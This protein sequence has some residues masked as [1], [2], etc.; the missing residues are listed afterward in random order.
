MHTTSASFA[1][2][3]SREAHLGATQPAAL[4]RHTYDSQPFDSCVRTFDTAQRHGSSLHAPLREPADSHAAGGFTHPHSAPS[5]PRFTSPG[6]ARASRAP[7]SK[8]RVSASPIRVYKVGLR[9]AAF[10]RCYA[11][12]NRMTAAKIALVAA[13]VVA[14]AS[15]A[16]ALL[17]SYGVCQTGCNILVVSCYAGAGFTFGT[18]TAG[19][20]VPAAII[21]CNSALGSCMA[22]CAVALVMPTP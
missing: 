21:A 9:I 11:T 4:Q 18:I 13:L 5:T 7:G 14:A 2:L 8:S 16:D 20:G 3:M 15:H 10:D 6:R 17:A 19:A 22:A 1:Q 12:E